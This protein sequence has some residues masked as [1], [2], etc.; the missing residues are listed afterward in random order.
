[1][2]NQEQT[3]TP[4]PEL[5]ITDLANLR[6]VVDVAFRRGA[7]SAAEASGVGSVFD[8]LNAFLVAVAPPAAAPEESTPESTA[9]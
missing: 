7:F 2:E 9:Q 1:M 6:S 5:T 3:N 8:K 4:A